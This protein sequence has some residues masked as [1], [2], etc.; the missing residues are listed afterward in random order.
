MLKYYKSSTASKI[1]PKLEKALP[2]ILELD[3]PIPEELSLDYDLAKYDIINSV[4]LPENITEEYSEILIKHIALSSFM[5]IKSAVYKNM[6]EKLIHLLEINLF[7]IILEATIMNLR[8][9]TKYKEF[10]IS[11]NG[12]KRKSFC[13]N[14]ATRTF[15]RYKQRILLG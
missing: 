4:K 5:F 8:D 3:S 7:P 15:E 2:P 10:M 9:P 11:I 14:T 13:R 1:D 12:K 6:N